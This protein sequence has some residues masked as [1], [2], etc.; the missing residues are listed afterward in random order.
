MACGLRYSIAEPGRSK[1]S[2]R[3]SPGETS[4]SMD[5]CIDD[6]E[7]SWNCPGLSGRG[8]RHTH[9]GMAFIDD[10]ASDPG[11]GGALRRASF[12]CSILAEKCAQSSRMVISI[13]AAAPSDPT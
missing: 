6:I 3:Y 2:T 4:T 1:A 5:S 12:G 7:I 8:T 13:A 10:A 11:F 9:T